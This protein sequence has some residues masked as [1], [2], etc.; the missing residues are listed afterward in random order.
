MKFFNRFKKTTPV[1][2]ETVD[3]PE[4]TVA[5][6]PI[7]DGY[8]HLTNGWKLEMAVPL[9]TLAGLYL[10]HGWV[11][12]VDGS[13]GHPMPNGLQS[14]ITA[15]VEHIAENPDAIYHELGRLLFLQD[16]D[17][18]GSVDIFLHIGT[19]SAPEITEVP[20]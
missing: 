3:S 19:A 9:R 1:E 16:D 15:Q 18:P 20:A 8:D 17:F 2:A 6:Q 14:F 13:F 5:D 7:P 11:M 4:W 12:S 10:A